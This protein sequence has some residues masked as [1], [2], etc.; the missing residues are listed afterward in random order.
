MEN[1]NPIPDGGESGEAYAANT[2]LVKV[3]GDTAR[4]KILA[5]LLSE[6]ERDLNVSDIARLAGVARTTVYDHIDELQELELIEQTRKVGD[7]PMYQITTDEK[8]VEHLA[9]VEALAGQKM[10]SEEHLVA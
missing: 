5:A 3:F 9:M 6:Q 8:L 10:V 2:P 7:S 4:A 1:S